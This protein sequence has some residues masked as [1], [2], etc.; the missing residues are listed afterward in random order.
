ML[1]PSTY[2]AD[3]DLFNGKSQA[4]RDLY[5]LLVDELN[6]LG[7]VQEVKK[8]MSISLE[9]RRPFASVLIRNRSLKLVLRTQRRIS[10]PRILSID[11]V[12]NKSY[13]HTI[14]LDSKNDIDDELLKWLGEAYHSSD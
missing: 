8:A 6:K 11:R 4:A 7:P 5:G 14:V 12:A 1:A 3:Q 13:D 10:N 2:L 9:N